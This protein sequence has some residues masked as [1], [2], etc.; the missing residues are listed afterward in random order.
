[1]D[2]GVAVVQHD[3][4]RETVT[5]RISELTQSAEVSLHHRCGRLNL[6]ARN[7][8]RPAFD[9]DVDLKVV[10][11]AEV[12][13]QQFVPR[14]PLQL[15][16]QRSHIAELSL[17]LRSCE[18]PRVAHAFGVLTRRLS[19]CCATADVPAEKSLEQGDVV[20]DGRVKQSR[21]SLIEQM[22]GGSRP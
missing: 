20:V 19:G 13:K 14:L 18:R 15:P 3:T 8:T 11:V 4:V 5:C 1:M 10:A 12:E 2:A 22:R 16:G 17:A 21:R 9:H 6:D 7:R